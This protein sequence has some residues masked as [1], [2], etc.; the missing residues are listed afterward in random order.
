MAD[1]PQKPERSTS[2]AK[3]LQP[4]ALS[5]A[6]SLKQE[7]DRAKSSA[8]KTLEQQQSRDTKQPA[9][10]QPAPQQHLRPQSPGLRRAVDRPLLNEQLAKVD[11]QSR[12]I[13]KDG[14][15]QLKELYQKH[16]RR[17]DKDHDKDNDD[18]SR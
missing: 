8:D 15:K 2:A 5:R 18:R 3:H 4:D 13:D 12:G 6:R 16:E 7:F 1:D 17:A 9:K 10:A 11:K 14:A